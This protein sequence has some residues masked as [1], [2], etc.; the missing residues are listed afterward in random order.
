[1]ILSQL[2][3]N[4][5]FSFIPWTSIDIYKIRLETE[6]YYFLSM[7]NAAKDFIF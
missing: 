3:A 1:M 2:E 5:P 4:L 7:V 6:T